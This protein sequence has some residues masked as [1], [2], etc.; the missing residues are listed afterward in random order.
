M[1]LNDETD[2]YYED[3]YEEESGTDWSP[4]R[5]IVGVAVAV[6]LAFVIQI[7]TGV[8]VPPGVEGALGIIAGYFTPSKR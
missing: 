3:D 2:G 5:K 4:E 8:E 6:V 7:T 1:V